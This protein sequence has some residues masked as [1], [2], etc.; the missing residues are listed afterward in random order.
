MPK[1]EKNLSF[2]KLS[3]CRE[4]M[5]VWPKK[6]QMAT[7]AN[8]GLVS[9]LLLIAAS[10]LVWLL[11]FG[12]SDG[13]PYAPH[14]AK[15]HA[16][17]SDVVKG[18][19]GER[20]VLDDLLLALQ[21]HAG[22]DDD[23]KR[24]E[25]GFAVKALRERTTQICQRSFRNRVVTLLPPSAV[26]N[27]HD[28]VLGLMADEVNFE[29]SNLAFFKFRAD[30]GGGCS[31]LDLQSY[32]LPD[33][34]FVEHAIEACRIA[35][36]LKKPLDS[37]IVFPRRL[38]FSF[39]NSSLPLDLRHGPNTRSLHIHSPFSRSSSNNNYNLMERLD[40]VYFF[41]ASSA[42]AGRSVEALAETWGFLLSTES[43]QPYFRNSTAPKKI[44][45]VVPLFEPAGF[46]LL[47][48]YAQ[49]L[50]TAFPRF[51]YFRV[52][53]YDA[54]LFEAAELTAFRF[55]QPNFGVSACQ[56]VTRWLWHAA[57]KVADLGIY[58]SAM[59]S[60]EAQQR[61]CIAMIKHNT[62]VR[63][64]TNRFFNLS[65][66]FLA[67]LVALGVELVAEDVPKRLRMDA[68]NTAELLLDSS[69]ATMM[70]NRMLLGGSAR[71]GTWVT[72]V[73]PEA[74]GHFAAP[75]EESSSSASSS[76]SEIQSSLRVS[77]SS[78]TETIFLFSD[79]NDWF[80]NGSRAK[81]KG[82]S[83]KHYF[84][85]P[86]TAV[87]DTVPVAILDLIRKAGCQRKS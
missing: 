4:R 3:L 2:S 9:F 76:A 11:H 60:D 39:Y 1:I 64:S 61:R 83:R 36:S 31:R 63:H 45:L 35:V 77:L 22:I 24:G 19:T 7:S 62:S 66:G 25:E 37:S 38:N 82:V 84:I 28:V 73:H 68:V 74:E 23:R 79:L 46:L 6:L 75:C 49:M 30:S 13:S 51:V 50:M 10:V 53:M 52:P 81:E 26:G 14:L 58:P 29:R 32:Q 17:V 48:E 34:E 70:I 5:S 57:L 67:Q 42:L 47:E 20:L 59:T 40:T 18:N 33:R 44:G 71:L 56:E 78:K 65:H 69:G 27:S 8:R 87:L 80:I 15:I 85:C 55:F 43:E 12:A 54:M 72:L 16:D 86:R 21:K 41:Y